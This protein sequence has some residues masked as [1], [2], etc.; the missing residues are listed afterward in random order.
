M[1]TITTPGPHPRPGAMEGLLLL[2]LGIVTMTLF[3]ICWKM[4]KKTRSKKQHNTTM[5]QNQLFCTTN[6][7]HKVV[8][9]TG[10]TSGIG[11]AT[12]I[13]FAAAGAQ[14][15]TV[16]GRQPQKWTQI[17]VPAIQKQL[18][19]EKQ[20]II[21]YKQC[22]VRIA[23][24]I[25]ALVQSIV[26]KEGR[27]DVAF[28]NAGIAAGAPVLQQT[29]QSTAIPQ[30][31]SYGLSAPQP[32][33]K[34]G[35]ESKQCN[36]ASLQTATSPFCENAIFTDGLGVFNS[37]KAELEVMVKQLPSAD[38]PTIVNTASVNSLWGSP[39][40]VF[41]AAAKAMVHLL[42]KG[43]AVEQCAPTAPVLP[44]LPIRVNCVMPGAVFTPLLADQIRPGATY[45]ETNKVASAGIPMGRIALPQEIAPTVLFLADNR[46]ASYITGASIVIDGG[47]TAAPNLSSTS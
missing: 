18:P 1:E 42:T 14:S 34:S 31:L 19:P 16:C 36:D 23:D 39:G 2:G 11:L 43:V 10:G 35:S 15:V 24:Q 6:F 29:L 44:N 30:G 40:G 32:W 20:S 7:A 21:Q 41:Y 3:A 46:R 26:A 22:D 37:M 28:N 8:L 27:L 45:E 9:I 17:A 5:F 4:K 12:A 25:R 13:A 38:P 33:T 47:L